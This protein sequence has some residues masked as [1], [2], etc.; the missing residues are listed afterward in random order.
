MMT[1]NIKIM[2]T[3]LRKTMIVAVMPALLIV[4]FVFAQAPLGS[5]QAQASAA[6]TV[7]LDGV[8]RFYTVRRA[9]CRWSSITTVWEKTLWAAETVNLA[10]RA[11][12]PTTASRSSITT[13]RRDH[14]TR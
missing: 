1:R 10:A 7:K 14:W 13:I 5:A 12:T 8:G 3:L 9:G 6:Q 11:Y 2:P 4:G